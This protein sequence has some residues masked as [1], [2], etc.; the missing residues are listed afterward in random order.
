MQCRA[1]G[2]PNDIWELNLSNA[3]YYQF[4]GEDSSALGTAQA[5]GRLKIEGCELATQKWVDNHWR[6][7]LWKIAGQ[8]MAKPSLFDQKWNWY[9]VLCQLRYR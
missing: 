6:L 4:I 9:E 2:R 3:L 5:L 7:I 8:V 1:D